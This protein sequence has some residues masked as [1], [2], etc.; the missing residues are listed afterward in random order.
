MN[1]DLKFNW[2]A[3]CGSFTKDQYGISST[4]CRYATMRT[5]KGFLCVR[6]HLQ[7]FTN[8]NKLI[9]FKNTSGRVGIWFPASY[10]IQWAV[11]D[12]RNIFQASDAS[13]WDDNVFYPMSWAE[14]HTLKISGYPTILDR[15]MST[16]FTKMVNKYICNHFSHLSRPN[17]ETH[18][19]KI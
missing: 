2:D 17:K 7:Y 13:D 8:S 19:L 4:K 16:P 14:N 6:K 15:H 10:F 1:F 12:D 11:S 5:L 9:L 3:L 18:G